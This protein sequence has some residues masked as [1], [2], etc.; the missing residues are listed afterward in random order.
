MRIEHQVAEVILHHTPFTTVTVETSKG[1]YQMSIRGH[2]H[3]Q[4]KT[5]AMAKK[6]LIHVGDLK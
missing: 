2:N 4:V 6:I 5:T 3:R 1:P